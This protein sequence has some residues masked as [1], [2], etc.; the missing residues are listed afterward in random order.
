[1]IQWPAKA[2]ECGWGWSY[3]GQAIL[4]YLQPWTSLHSFYLQ[5]IQHIFD[6][7]FR[8][9]HRVE[10]DAQLDGQETSEGGCLRDED[11]EVAVWGSKAGQSIWRGVCEIKES[12]LEDRGLKHVSIVVLIIIIVNGWLITLETRFHEICKWNLIT[13]SLS[14]CLQAVVNK[15][16]LKSKRR[17]DDTYWEYLRNMANH[18]KDRVRVRAFQAENKGVEI[19]GRRT[20]DDILFTRV[21]KC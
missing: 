19:K 18:I 10:D 7:M 13:K 2:E 5:L 12:D 21:L 1:M 14:L 16:F 20:Y 8:E 9:E 4:M 3:W 17:L 6:A 15:M 11:S